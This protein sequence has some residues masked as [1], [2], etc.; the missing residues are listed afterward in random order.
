MLVVTGV[1]EVAPDCIEAA[2]E[3]VTA[4]TDETRKEAGC[5][6]YEFSQLVEAPQR[7]RVYEEWEDAESLSSHAKSP[8]MATFRAALAKIGVVSREVFTIEGETKTR[9][10]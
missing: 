4:M 3:A 7:F 5:L 10:G 9:L 6:V 8:H 1:I 2:R